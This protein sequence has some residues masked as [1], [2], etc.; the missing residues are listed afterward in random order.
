MFSFEIFDTAFDENVLL[1]YN[2]LKIS[3][4]AAST[5]GHEKI[6]YIV[7]Y[8]K[9]RKR[10]RNIQFHVSSNQISIEKLVGNLNIK[11]YFMQ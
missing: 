6:E 2:Y 11:R 1:I 9:E 4:I 7:E 8:I 10:K 3:I 5:S